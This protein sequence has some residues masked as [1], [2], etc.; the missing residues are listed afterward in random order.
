M[1]SRASPI[2]ILEVKTKQQMTIRE[3]IFYEK[4]GANSF[5]IEL[6]DYLS[7]SSIF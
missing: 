6:Y 2:Q 4:K 7:S 5:S 1:A 3:T